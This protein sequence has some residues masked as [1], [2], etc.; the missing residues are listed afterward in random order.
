MQKI[1]MR[2]MDLYEVNCIK[3]YESALLLQRFN[4]NEGSR[5]SSLLRTFYSAE[6]CFFD[7]EHLFLGHSLWFRIGV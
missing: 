5:T 2:S 3:R 4:Y 6:E 7:I 1:A